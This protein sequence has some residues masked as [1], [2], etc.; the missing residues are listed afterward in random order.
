M[1]LTVLPLL[2]IRCVFIV[3]LFLD[4][5]SVVKCL[6]RLRWLVMLVYLSLNLQRISWGRSGQGIMY[7]SKMQ[8]A[9]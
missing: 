6:D 9:T 3:Y 8:A 4:V 5:V 1:D 2:L 7:V